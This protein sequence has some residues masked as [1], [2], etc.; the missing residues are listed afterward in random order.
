MR[1]RRLAANSALAL[2]GDLASKLG[3]FAVLFAGAR[4]LSIGEFAVLATG[5]AAASLLTAGLELG[6]GTLLSRDGVGG[7]KARGRLFRALLI[8]RAPFAAGLLVCAP[9]A[10][11]AV[12][13]PLA[14]LAIAALAV[15]GAPMLTVLGLYRSAQDLRPE[16]IQKLGAA[17]LSVAA[18]AVCATFAGRGDAVLGAIAVA[19]LISLAPM[20][21]RAPRIAHFERGPHWNALLRAAPIGLI[22]LATLGYY[23]SG[24]LAL[25]MFGDTHAIAAFSVA[26]SVAFG[27]LAFPNAITTALL[28]RLSSGHESGDV[29]AY[30]RRALG[31]TLVLTVPLAAGAAAAGPFVLPAML[32]SEYRS[33]AA[34]LALLCAGLPLIATSGVIGTALLAL[35]RLREL[36]LQVTASLAVNLVAL[37]LL[38]PPFGAVGAAGA[39]LACEAVGLAALA[40]AAGR[41]LPGLFLAPRAAT[42]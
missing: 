10:G 31:W 17:L 32:G 13:R 23:R 34:P 2:A 35:G 15:V 30:T 12:G 22:G 29:V 1:Q 27:V 5:L 28:P 16:A 21:V 40:V 24:T 25:A 37:V 6:A 9:F 8:S 41:R 36:G 39:T 38:I 20:L 11:L 19:T 18:V 7:A 26:T 14:A 3:G 4:L 33:A 42:A